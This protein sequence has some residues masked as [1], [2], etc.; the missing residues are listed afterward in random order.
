M[1]V[2]LCIIQRLETSK[3]C[4]MTLPLRPDFGVHRLSASG[5]LYGLAGL[6]FGF[7][8]L[9]PVARGIRVALTERGILWVLDW[10]EGL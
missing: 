2:P 8:D 6:A 1:K 4:L 9:V 3:P 5:F 10:K 7:A